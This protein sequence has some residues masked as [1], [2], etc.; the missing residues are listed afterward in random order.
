MPVQARHPQR[1]GIDRIADLGGEEA[2]V[3]QRVDEAGDALGLRLGADRTRELGDDIVVRERSRGTVGEDVMR[4]GA[5]G[6]LLL[7]GEEL[8][9]AVGLVLDGDEGVD[10][11]GV[12]LRAGV[13]AQV[14]HGRVV[15]PGLLVGATRRQGVVAVGDR[16]DAGRERNALSR[17]AAG[18]AAAVP[19]LVVT[20]GDVE[21]HG[22]EALLGRR[23]HHAADGLGPDGRVLL[24][25]LPLALVE[26]AGLQQDR[27]G[28]ADLA[29]VVQGSGADDV[30]ENS[31]VIAS[32]CTPRARR[33]SATRRQ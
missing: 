13:L 1:V 9:D 20:P 31:S 6:G 5:G 23:L 12:E 29:D 16:E 21:A 8:A 7:V 3:E 25:D 27:V 14:G 26:A 15:G 33:D 11:V 17:Q 28:D 18:V 2:R 19:A 10:G 4:V 22:Q 32:A 30:L 24:H